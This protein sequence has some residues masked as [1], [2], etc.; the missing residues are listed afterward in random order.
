MIQFMFL[1]VS[2]VKKVEYNVDFHVSKGL[3]TSNKIEAKKFF[4]SK[5]NIEFMKQY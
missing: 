1:R 3:P 5:S 4:F 2:Y